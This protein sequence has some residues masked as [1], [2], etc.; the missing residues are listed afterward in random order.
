MSTTTPTQ[1]RDR[2]QTL[3]S[4]NHGPVICNERPAY[5]LPARPSGPNAPLA[6]LSDDEYTLLIDQILEDWDC[7]TLSELGLCRAHHLTLEELDQITDDPAFD[8]ALARIRSI[9]EKRR[10]EREAAAHARVVD[11]LLGLLEQPQDTA[12]RAKE[13]RLTAK[14]LLS[15]LGRAGFQPAEGLGEPGFQ[16]ADL[17][18]AGFQPANLGGAG[19]QPANRPQADDHHARPHPESSRP[20]PPPPGGRGPG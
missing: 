18:R 15:I 13:V 3:Y 14:Q 20:P 16:P 19:F 2:A 17:G 1:R 8:R 5:V 7:A 4:R 6:H 11:R 10:P 12:T 9:R